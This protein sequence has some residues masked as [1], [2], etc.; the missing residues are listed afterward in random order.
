MADSKY[1][2]TYSLNNVYTKG[3]RTLTINTANK[4]LAENVVVKFDISNQFLLDLE[5]IEIFTDNTDYEH[6]EIYTSVRLGYPGYLAN[7]E[8]P[9][10]TTILGVAGKYTKVTDATIVANDTTGKISSALKMYTNDLQI[11]SPSLKASNII[12]GATILGVAGTA[13]T[14]SS[15]KLTTYRYDFKPT[16]QQL[17]DV[18]YTISPSTGYNGFSEIQMPVIK[19]ANI[20]VE[21]S[22]GLKLTTSAVA[23]PTNGLTEGQNSTLDGSFKVT[24]SI[25][26]ESIWDGSFSIAT[27]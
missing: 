17:T 6:S 5:N 20:T 18:F 15:V 13:A 2:I 1:T 23:Y 9:T 3:F 4:W 24:T 27:E 25:A 14:A 12:A 22:E 21:T 11:T 19:A 26:S 16:A 8:W 7:K 10:G